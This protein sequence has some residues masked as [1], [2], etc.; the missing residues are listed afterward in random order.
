MGDNRLASTD[1]RTCFSSCLIEGKS[2][3]IG[4]KDII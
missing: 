4:E 3:Y 1:S 2:N